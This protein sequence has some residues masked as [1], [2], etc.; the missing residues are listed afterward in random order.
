MDRKDIGSGVIGAILS[1]LLVVTLLP[2]MG[3]QFAFADQ[4]APDAEASSDAATS[5]TAKAR[6]E[7][8]GGT[9]ALTASAAEAAAAGEAATSAAA[10]ATS[11]GA[12]DADA[13]VPVAHEREDGMLVADGLVYTVTDGGLALVGFDA[14]SAAAQDVA[15]EDA[16]AE[17]EGAA[18]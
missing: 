3:I 12:A 16:A 14:A 7:V 4:P 11:A 17:G 13:E 18:A 15:P 5:A 10:V 6:P 1:A 8:T 2:A 9:L